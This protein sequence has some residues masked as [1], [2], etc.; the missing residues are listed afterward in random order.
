MKKKLTLIALLFLFMTFRINAQAFDK[1]KMDSLFKRIENNEKGMGSISIFKNKNEIY[2]NSFGFADIENKIRS[3]KK[4]KYRIGSFSKTFTATII[5]QLIDENK[6]SLDTKLGEFYPDIPNAKKI[7]IEQLLRHRSGLYN[8]TNSEDYQNWM[9]KP[10][11]KSEVLKIFIE[12]GIVFKPDEKAEYSNTNYILLSY[13]AE[14][15]ELKEYSEIL[16]KRIIDPCRLK[17]T[18]YGGKINTAENEALSYTKLAAWELATETDMSVPAGAGGIVSNSTD[19]NIFYNHL[20]HGKLVSDNLLQEM[21]KIVDSYGIGMFQL[22]DKK[23]FGH[24]GGIDGFQSK[25][26]YFP[27]DNIFIAY[28]SNGVAMPMNDILIGALDIYYGNEYVLPE[29]EISIELRSED[30]D[31]YLGV[32]SS[33]TNPLKITISKDG[34]VLIAQATG[35]PSFPLEAYEL[36]KFKFDPAKI[37]FEFIPEENKMILKQGGGEFELMRE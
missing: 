8:L 2:Q 37:E 31:K 29:F 12:N 26:T 34:T 7:T 10:H 3:T 21:K 30:L 16:N 35:Q 28:T 4:T 22:F 20:F 24:T 9:V 33:S 32:Y 5:M 15:I 14:K 27:E 18:Y 25:V 1:A 11:S 19:L 13:I 23:G 36:H 17:N 6:L